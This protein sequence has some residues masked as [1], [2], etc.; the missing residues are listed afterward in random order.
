MNRSTEE[1]TTGGLP[2]APGV[3]PAP[4]T[5]F[6]AVHP[7][8]QASP[9]GGANG[10][11]AGGSTGPPRRRRLVIL[12]AAAVVPLLIAAP[13]LVLRRG[14]P[15]DTVRDFYAALADRD[16]TRARALL[17]PG[18][19]VGADNTLLTNDTLRNPGYTPPR[20]VRVTS[21]PPSN[22]QAAEDNGTVVQAE[23]E[24]GD[25]SLVTHLRLRKSA[26]VVGRWQILDGVRQ[27]GVLGGVPD[28]RYLFAGTPYPA[29]TRPWVAFPGAYVA[30]LAEH[31]IFEAAPV[32]AIANGGEAPTLEPKVRASARQ[33]IEREVRAYLDACATSPELVPPRCPFPE[34]HHPFVDTAHIRATKISRKITRYPTLRIER[35]IA[36][37]T[38]VAVSTD[39]PG[40]VELVARYSPSAAPFVDV[41]ESFQVSGAVRLN[42]GRLVFTPAY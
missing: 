14:G 24:V 18:T 5:P 13:A 26:P 36:V 10:G 16:A 31:P 42:D 3:P 29:G 23:Y 20:N 41:S 2:A 28:A 8:T 30:V 17:A 37:D 32:T 12:V 25:V 40:Q 7:T 19:V 1:P 22:P 33:E 21:A 27:L 4:A 38:P 34:H 35:D 39:L 9:A 11:W 6:P 15:E